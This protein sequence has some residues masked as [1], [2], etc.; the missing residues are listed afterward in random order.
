MSDHRSKG[1]SSPVVLRSSKVTARAV[2][3]FV[4]ALTR[5]SMEKYGF[6]TA[7]LFADWAQIVG[8]DLATHATPLRLRWPRAATDAV[9]A[10][11]E[12]VGRGAATLHLQVNAARALDVQYKAAQ[13]VD[14]INAYFGYRAV[15]ELRIV[16]AP[17]PAAP[18]PTT[19]RDI[20]S[21]MSARPA[22]T[23][24]QLAS[25]GD[26]R[27]RELLERLQQGIAARR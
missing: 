16:Q 13:I 21:V 5:K 9:E 2:G 1:E 8:S 17:V 27:L 4:P 7:A 10:T 20:V 6:S 24:A 3:S 14:R 22:S 11:G 15:G 25:V 12:S 23:G 19:P 26:E 18:R